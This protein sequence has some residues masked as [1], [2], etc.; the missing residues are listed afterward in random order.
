MNRIYDFFLRQL[1][2]SLSSIK[3]QTPFGENGRGEITHGTQ[4][5]DETTVATGEISLVFQPILKPDTRAK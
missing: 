4:P 5:K 3:T 1:T 2:L